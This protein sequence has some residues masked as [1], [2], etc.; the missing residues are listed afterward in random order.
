MAPNE[1]A[2]QKGVPALQ[3]VRLPEDKDARSSDRFWPVPVLRSKSSRQEW[4]GILAFDGSHCPETA[5][6]ANHTQHLGGAETAFGSGCWTKPHVG[7]IP[8]TRS[9]FRQ[10]QPGLIRHTRAWGSSP[11]M[12]SVS[13]GISTRRV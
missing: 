12:A 13:W 3:T 7:S 5:S 6:H 8:I 11:T 2:N 10:C 4:V 9:N 1:S